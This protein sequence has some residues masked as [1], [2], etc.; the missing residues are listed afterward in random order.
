M[1]MGTVLV[2]T[3][4]SMGTVLVD[5]FKDTGDSRVWIG[6]ARN[7]KGNVPCDKENRPR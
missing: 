3:F 1:S 6:V 7:A 2:D 4:M 5:T